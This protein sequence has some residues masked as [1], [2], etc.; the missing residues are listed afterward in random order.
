MYAK[1]PGVRLP[2]ISVP[3]NKGMSS[4]NVFEFPYVV[5]EVVFDG[6]DHHGR[7]CLGVAGNILQ[8]WVI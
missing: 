8:S 1:E 6:G 4:F 3:P 2:I 7:G 5:A